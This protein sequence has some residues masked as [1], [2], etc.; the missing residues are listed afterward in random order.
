MITVEQLL[1]QAVQLGAADVYIAAGMKP[2]AKVCG[3]FVELD[4]PDLSGEETSRIIPKMM[5]DTQQETYRKNKSADFMLSVKTVGQFRVHVYEQEG[6]PACCIRVILPPPE[7]SKDLQEVCQEE[8]GLIIVAGKQGCGKSTTLAGMVQA[9]NQNRAVHIITLEQ[10]IERKFENA[11]GIVSQREIG[12]DTGS[13]ISAWRDI[14]HESA[15][16]VVFGE[17]NSAE[18]I[19]TAV[20]AAQMG[21]L[22]FASMNSMNA[23]TVVREL[24]YGLGK[25]EEQA[26]RMVSEVLRTVIYQS[27]H[28]NQRTGQAELETQIVKQL[29]MQ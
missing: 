24:T 29:K 7:L 5:K 10:P 2:K 14:L 27:L 18:A 22:V 11:L 15:D 4:Y 9:I 8:Q 16:V 1:R 25:P 19:Q 13:Y 23:E 26:S 21:Y 6:Y 20:S 3:K 17:L 12:R 28:Y